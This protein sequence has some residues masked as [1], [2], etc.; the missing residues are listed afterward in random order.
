MHVLLLFLLLQDLVLHADHLE[1]ATRG[2]A[3]RRHIVAILTAIHVAISGVDRGCALDVDVGAVRRQ[4]V[5]G[6]LLVYWDHDQLGRFLA[7]LPLSLLDQFPLLLEG[8]VSVHVVRHVKLIIALFEHLV[9]LLETVQED[10]PIE[11]VLCALPLVLPHLI[12]LLLL[13]GLTFLFLEQLLPDLQLEC[14]IFGLHLDQLVE[15]D[16][17]VELVLGVCFRRLK[18]IW[19]LDPVDHLAVLGREL[20]FDL[21]AEPG[22]ISLVFRH[23]EEAVCFEKLVQ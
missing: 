18:E 6:L 12:V 19:L 8:V 14:A 3:P 5:L 4:C 16:W 1:M 10:V 17:L 9:L 23:F 21:L 2:S 7:A 20:I 13:L 22:L 11:R 15:L